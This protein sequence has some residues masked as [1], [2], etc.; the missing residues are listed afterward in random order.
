[1]HI[2]NKKQT[3]RLTLL[4]VLA[5]V[6]IAHVYTLGDGRLGYYWDTTSYLQ[7]AK[8][9]RAH[10]EYPFANYITTP[11]RFLAPKSYAWGYPLLLV[12]FVTDS[13]INET[14]IRLLQITLLLIIVA[15]LW[16]YARDSLPPH[17]FAAA[18]FLLALNPLI[19]SINR[20]ATPQL[21]FTMF[22]AA[23][24]VWYSQ[25]LTRHPGQRQ[26]ITAATIGLLLGLAIATR[27]HGLLL[28]PALAL[29]EYFSGR[30]SIRIFLVTLTSAAVCFFVLRTLLIV[31]PVTSA[32]AA[33][34]YGDLLASELQISGLLERLG[35]NLWRW[36]E[37]ALYLNF[38]EG[39]PLATRAATILL[40]GLALFGYINKCRTRPTAVEFW[41]PMH[42][43][44]LLL[45][46]F[47][48]MLYAAPVLPFYAYYVLRACNVVKAPVKYGLLTGAA[49]FSLAGYL[50][51]HRTPPLHSSESFRE[52]AS[53]ELYQWLGE[54]TGPDDLLFTPFVRQMAFFT[55]RKATTS[56]IDFTVERLS[57]YVWEV[58]PDYL[59]VGPSDR[60]MH[61]GHPD[62]LF[63][64]VASDTSRFVPVFA[65]NLYDVYR[66]VQ[67]E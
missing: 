50:P 30:K 47:A 7:H 41:I 32:T 56:D 62:T 39:V 34:G 5:V 2:S 24:L 23:V 31:D 3:D 28:L 66:V 57:Q 27:T 43:A 45:F 4:A 63:A 60:P 52:E 48:R 67:V 53:E 61:R 16:V 44:S 55:D 10:A 40:L 49:L 54:T 51:L 15:L 46:S 36:I 14:G 9:I 8:N 58:D 22:A 64:V 65:N 17:Y 6:A 33:S 37:T 19:I 21:A 26:Q 35:R 18:A 29:Y 12:P 59:I 25:P 1:M 13:S 11:E 42:M 38:I 20:F